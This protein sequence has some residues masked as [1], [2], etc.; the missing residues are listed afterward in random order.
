MV[1]LTH[2]IAYYIFKPI[3]AKIGLNSIDNDEFI[4]LY[5]TRNEYKFVFIFYIK[6]NTPL[7]LFSSEY[8]INSFYLNSY[9]IIEMECPDNLKQDYDN[10]ILGKYSKIK[11]NHKIIIKNESSLSEDDILIRAIY[12]DGKLKEEIENT[13]NV[14]LNDNDELYEYPS[15]SIITNLDKFYADVHTYLFEDKQLP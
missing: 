8:Y 6:S 2:S 11:D 12:K 10:F 9:L 1:S 13:L 4:D 3:L 5:I 14:E 15:N 7:D